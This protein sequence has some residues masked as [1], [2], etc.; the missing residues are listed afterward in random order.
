LNPKAKLKPSGITWLGDIP[1]N[2]DARRLKEVG[3][4]LG[5]AGFPYEEQGVEGEE[6]PFYKVGDLKASLDGRMMGKPEHTISKETAK[7]LRASI[8]PPDSIVYAKIGAAL[9]LNRRRITFV[10]CCIDNNM[11]AY[12]P[13][14]KYIETNW[15]FYW[16]SILDF[17]EFMNPGA[18]PSFSE[19]YQSILP[20][21]VPSLPEQTAI[22]EYLDA[23]T[24][25]LDALVVKVETAVERLQEYRTALITAAVTGKID[26]R[27]AA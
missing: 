27:K 16:L 6:L 13:G 24:K 5:G 20:I 22:T 17:G 7:K 26:V 3:T 14:K 2:W 12:V 8:I 9:L 19:G 25:K 18:V 4:L 10:N 15:A 21:L 23:E 11:T 1:T